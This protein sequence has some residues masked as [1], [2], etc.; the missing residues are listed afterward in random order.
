MSKNYYY[1]ISALPELRLDDYKEPYRVKEFAAELSEHLDHGDY[2][3]VKGILHVFDNPNLVD[4]ALGLERPWFEYT[5][6]WTFNELKK[7]FPFEDDAE[8][9]Y[10]RL[11]MRGLQDLKKEKEELTRSDIETMIWEKFYAMMLNSDNNFIRRYFSFDCELKNILSAINARRFGLK[12]SSLLNLGHSQVYEQL[13]NSSS[14]DFGLSSNYEFIPALQEKIS[15]A[16]VAHSEKFIDQLRWNFIDE[17]NTFS[18]FSIDVLLGFLL[19]LIAVERWI[20]LDDK[21]GSE[22][23]KKLTEIK[24]EEVNV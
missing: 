8:D 18:Y 15:K 16:E 1:L 22:A 19:K 20:L 5:G 14:Q 23:F 9:G 24:L 3:Y 13:V 7:R 17:I 10:L 6:N 11:F 4:C 21:K 2:R 12:K